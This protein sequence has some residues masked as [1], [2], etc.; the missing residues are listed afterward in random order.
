[1]YV[2]SLVT[3]HDVEV[4]GCYKVIS[5]DIYGLVDIIDDVGE[6]YTLASIEYVEAGKESYVEHQ[7]KRRSARLVGHSINGVDDEY[8]EAYLEFSRKTEW[9]TKTADT[10]ELG[11]HR[12]DI[13]RECI[14]ALQEE[15]AELK[16]RIASLEK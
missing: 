3:E 16:S 5:K 2:T 15:N 9:L 8:K 12:A 14:E 1:M 7:N 6:E 13:L 4:G 11:K 10:S